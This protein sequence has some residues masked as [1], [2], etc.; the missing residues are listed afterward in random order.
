MKLLLL[1]AISA[2][3]WTG[4]WAGIPWKGEPRT[5]DWWKSRHQLMLNQTRDHKTDLKVIF[6]GDSITEGWT[7]STGKDLW[8]KSYAPRHAY[9]Y[10]IGGDKTEHLIWRM[11]N[12]EF[13]GLDSRVVVLKIGTNNLFDNTVEDIAKGIREI[14]DQLVRRQ[15]NTK[16]LLL[17]IIPRQGRDLELKV[18]SIN[19]IISKYG[20]NKR[21]FYLDMTDH[22]ETDIGVEIADLYSD[23][24]HLTVKGYQVWHD[25]MEPLFSKLLN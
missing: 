25:V 19:T 21:V 14:V 16:V 7:T 1:L 3:V 20:D 5:D 9:N 2:F 18:Q 24:V 4:C 10:G 12:G 11:E 6:F 13:D 23:T 15:V 8:A 22:F 17:A